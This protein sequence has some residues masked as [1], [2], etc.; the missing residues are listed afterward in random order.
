MFLRETPLT[1]PDVEIEAFARAVTEPDPVARLHALNAAVNRKFALDRGRPVAGRTAIEAFA[2]G[3]VS[4]RDL[5]QVFVTAARCLGVP[6]RYVSG[7][8]PACVDV[9][10]RPAPHGP[11]RAGSRST[12]RYGTEGRPQPQDQ[13]RPEREPTRRTAPGP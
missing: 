11:R 9:D 7:Y 4:S 1:T 3:A 13:A 12:A 5:A 6:A 8:S 10:G 2:E